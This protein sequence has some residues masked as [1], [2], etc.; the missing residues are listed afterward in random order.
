MK[1]IVIFPLIPA[2]FIA[3]MRGIPREVRI[4]AGI[5]SLMII[6]GAMIR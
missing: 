5:V 2:L 1:L 4:L 6:I 3:G